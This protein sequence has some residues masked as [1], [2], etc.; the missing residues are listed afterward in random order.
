MK[1]DQHVLAAT[2]HLHHLRDGEH[3]HE[4]QRQRQPAHAAGVV[5]VLVVAVHLRINDLDC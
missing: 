2:A 5:D 3:A 4:D 1:H